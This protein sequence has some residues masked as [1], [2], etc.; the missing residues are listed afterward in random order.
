[1]L[2]EKKGLA[3]AL[4]FSIASCSLLNTSVDAQTRGPFDPRGGNTSRKK[5]EPKRTPMSDKDIFDPKKL[6]LNVAVP[7]LDSFDNEPKGYIFVTKRAAVGSADRDL[8]GYYGEKGSPAYKRACLLFCPS[9][10][11]ELDATYLYVIEDDNF[12]TL[13]TRAI[14]WGESDTEYSDDGRRKY[15]TKIS[16]RSKPVNIRQIAINGKS[17]DMSPDNFSQVGDPQGTN[18]KYFPRNKGMFGLF[19]TT[20]T[21]SD[22]TAG[23]ITDIHIFPADELIAAARPLSKSVTIQFPRNSWLPAQHVIEGDQLIELKKVLS[24][25]DVDDY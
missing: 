14:G 25:C 16:Y 3:L 9:G 1:M 20:Q 24:N 11:K 17:I 8:G 13:G 2:N 5:R 22:L 15:T 6:N 10:T 18:S 19:Q 12:C 7:Y 4:A 21:S 23:Y